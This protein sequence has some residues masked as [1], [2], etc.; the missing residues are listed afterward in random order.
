MSQSQEEDETQVLFNT[1]KLSRGRRD[2]VGPCS[3][4]SLDA[5]YENDILL[6]VEFHDTEVVLCH[7][8]EGM[9]LS[10]LLGNYLKRINRKSTVGFT[11][12]IRRDIVDATYD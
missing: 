11:D 12:P 7:V 4:C 2:K 9:L 6:V 1:V 3:G 10:K 5:S 8:C